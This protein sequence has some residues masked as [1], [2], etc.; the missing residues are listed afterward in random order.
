MSFIILALSIIL[1]KTI[2]YLILHLD[3]T[4]LNRIKEVYDKKINFR[5]IKR[6]LPEVI[7]YDVMYLVYLKDLVKLLNINDIKILIFLIAITDIIFSLVFINP[8]NKI[9][10]LSYSFCSIIYNYVLYSFLI[11]YKHIILV[12]ITHY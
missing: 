6:I 2:S 3:S 9:T 11:K 10:A 8:Q 12:T 5:T 4:S 7:V 1:F